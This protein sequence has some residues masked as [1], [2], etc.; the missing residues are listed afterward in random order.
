M[1]QQWEL[2]K[3][4]A[5]F[6]TAP[7]W[8]GQFKLLVSEYLERRMQMN[9]ISFLLLI[10][11]F[12][13]ACAFSVV[14]KEKDIGFN[15]RLTEDIYFEKIY[16]EDCDV[17]ENIDCG[18]GDNFFLKRINLEIGEINSN[19]SSSYKNHIQ[20]KFYKKPSSAFWAYVNLISLG[21]IPT[22]TKDEFCLETKQ[23]NKIR[24]I[25]KNR[26]TYHWLPF[27][28]LGGTSGPGAAKVKIFI[29]L[30]KKEIVRISN[31]N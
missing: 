7:P 9:K 31:E 21:T 28:M 15:L 10:T 14:P 29:S 1:F 6:F 5:S 23:N 24:E 22:F 13:N 18:R 27:V 30:L 17:L 16:I 12:L 25:C 8:D 19:N 11:I 4:L 26:T 2:F 3:I 20:F